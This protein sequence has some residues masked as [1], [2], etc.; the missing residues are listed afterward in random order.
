MAHAGGEGGEGGSDMDFTQEGGEGGEGGEAGQEA[1]TGDVIGDL[2][3]GEQGQEQGGAAEDTPGRT[4]E[5]REEIF[6]VQQIYALR[7]NRV[8][9]SPSVA[10][11]LND[12]FVSHVGLGIGLNYWWTNVLAIGANFLW[13]EGL[14]SESNLN[15]FIRRSTRL[16]VPISQYQ[17]GAHLN[18]TY[19]PLYGKF[20]MFNEFIF[21]WDAY[22]VGG[23]GLMRTRPV[24][25]VDPEV[26]RFDY[27]I[28]IAFNVG[29]GLRVF[30]SRWLAVFGE[31]R[32]YMY[33]EQ[34]EALD[35]ALGTGRTDRA[36][37][38]QDSPAFTNN[39]TVHLGL[40]IFFPFDFD[41]RLPR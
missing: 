22:V 41:Y 31:I 39:V 7:I 9:V 26:R 19:V 21:Q 24:P 29:L 14:E 23:V 27:D 6:A 25:V 37:W 34:L 13:Y 28:R 35:V 3:G 32:N 16:A 17:F 38:T 36:T 10:F 18:F 15:F 4:N 12:P 1:G 5:A 33:L 20:A 11:T 2:A 30:V 40:T 8:E